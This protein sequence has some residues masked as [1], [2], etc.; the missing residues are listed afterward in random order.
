SSRSCRTAADSAGACRRGTAAPRGFARDLPGPTGRRTGPRP[1]PP[2]RAGGAHRARIVTPH[3]VGG[4]PHR[5]P[6]RSG[7]GEGFVGPDR[8]RGTAGTRI[9]LA[10]GFVLVAALTLPGCSADR[11]PE[12]RI[13]A[14]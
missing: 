8:Q 1:F 10:A 14:L 12:G 7:G 5:Y 3:P 9:G 6:R 13:R 11:S 4:L 2:G